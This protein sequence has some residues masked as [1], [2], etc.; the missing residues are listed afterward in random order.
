MTPE[1]IDALGVT[2]DVP[3][4]CRAIGISKSKGYQAVKDG[5]FPVRVIK[6]GSRYLVPTA[7]LRELLGMAEGTAA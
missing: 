3:T 2:T 1:E 4:A 6:V 5:T 7:G